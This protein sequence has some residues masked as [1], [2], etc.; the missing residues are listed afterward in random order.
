VVHR[1]DP[2]TLIRSVRCPVSL[3]IATSVE[4]TG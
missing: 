2:L 4:Q 3:T 1:W